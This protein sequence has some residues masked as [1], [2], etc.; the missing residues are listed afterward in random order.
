MCFYFFGWV[1]VF[2]GVSVCMVVDLEILELYM[3]SGDCL[4]RV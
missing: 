1:L 3:G 2:F 4:I